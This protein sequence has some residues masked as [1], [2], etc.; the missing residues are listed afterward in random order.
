M[1][2]L[3]KPRIRCNRSYLQGWINDYS[4]HALS[5]YTLLYCYLVELSLLTICQQR[6]YHQTDCHIKNHVSVTFAHRPESIRVVEGSVESL[7]KHKIKAKMKV[8]INILPTKKQFYTL[9]H[10]QNEGLCMI[11]HMPYRNEWLSLEC[12]SYEF[13][14]LITTTDELR[15]N[16]LNRPYWFI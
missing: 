7:I 12:S 6:D 4:G 10:L 16:C 5:C 9:D 15:L 3:S 13:S 8:D 14:C 1:Y 11:S 2:Y